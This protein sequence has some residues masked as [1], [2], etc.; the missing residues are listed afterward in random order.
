M[1]GA[2][3]PRMGAQRRGWLMA[4][5]AR[6]TAWD[7]RLGRRM[8][9]ALVAVTAASVSVLM[10][11]LLV[12]VFTGPQWVFDSP[13]P[14]VIPLLTAGIFGPLMANAFLIVL[15]DAR[16]L[17]EAYRQLAEHDQL[18][19]TFNRRGLF[20]RVTHLPIGSLVLIADI[21]AFKSV[22]DEY[23]HDHGDRVLI[24]TTSMLRELAGPEA[25]IARIGGDEFV[26][27]VPPGV[28]IDLPQPAKL[29]LRSCQAGTTVSIGQALHDGVNFDTTLA[30]ADAHLY[31]L[32]PQR[33]R[34]AHYPRSSQE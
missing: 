4:F 26:V 20:S 9:L 32:K 34:L 30:A 25:I 27:V 29:A 19:G 24:A 8:L 12:A 7:D 15:D 10:S 23:G 5:F 3:T 6:L 14:T 31:A 11:W 1:S 18:T 22:N 2:A 21:D 16:E 17:G 28:D 13:M 33:S